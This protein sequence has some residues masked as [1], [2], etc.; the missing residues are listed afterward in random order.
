MYVRYV[1]RRSSHGYAKKKSCLFLD[2][3]SA[4]NSRFIAHALVS[5]GRLT[6]SEICPLNLFPSFFFSEPEF[7]ETRLLIDVATYHR[8]QFPG[9]RWLKGFIISNVIQYLL[10]M[11]GHE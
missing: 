10:T 4:K 3:V 1:L 9:R 8:D 2:T 7:E 6:C 5:L 11:H